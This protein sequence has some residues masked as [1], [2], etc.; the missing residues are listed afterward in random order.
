MSGVLVPGKR[1]DNYCLGESQVLEDADP[2]NWI[3][4]KGFIGNDDHTLQETCGRRAAALAQG[5]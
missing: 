1:H 2:L 5:V 3:G 4:D